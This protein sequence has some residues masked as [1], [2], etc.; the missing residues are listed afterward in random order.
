MAPMLLQ[1][2]KLSWQ[3]RISNILRVEIRNVD[4]DAMFHFGWA[5]LM[6]QAPPVFVLLEIIGHMF[7]DENVSSITA[8]HYP[9][10]DVD[11]RAG[12]VRLIFQRLT[13]FQC[14]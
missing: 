1:H 5:K 13:N 10:R 9:L 7:G 3:L 6:Q 4:A 12:D 8:I 2:L 14:A 11:P